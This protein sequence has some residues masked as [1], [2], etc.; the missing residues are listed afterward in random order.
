MTSRPG[1][2]AQAR[3]IA[4]VVL[5]AVG[6]PAATRAEA[7]PAS[8]LKAAFL[9]HFAQF[10]EWPADALPSDAPIA[11]CVIGDDAVAS[12]FE[13]T[14]RDRV[15]AAHALALR[16]LRAGDSTRSCQV[17]FVS[18]SEPR[19]AETIDAIKG[20]PVFTVSDKT[21]F[22]NEGGMVELFLESGHMRFAV[23]V[24]AVQRSRVRVSSRVLGLAKIVR[25]GHVQ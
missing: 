16:R 20:A 11:V 25:D 5:L 15:V 7:V 8:A 17:L 22:A 2:L 12:A 9:L 18:G 3:R 14:A 23:N 1:P 13:T 24:D 21:R 4:L 19:L 10:V 6:V